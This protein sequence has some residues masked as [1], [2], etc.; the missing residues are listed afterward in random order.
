MLKAAFR[1]DAASQDQIL[2]NVE[3]LRAAVSSGVFVDEDGQ[4]A[5]RG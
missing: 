2:R 3:V 5:V 1:D 4:L